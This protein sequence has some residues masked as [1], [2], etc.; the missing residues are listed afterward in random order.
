MYPISELFGIMN[1]MYQGLVE[2][3]GIIFLILLPF[4]IG[5][6]IHG[7]LCVIFRIHN[8]RAEPLAKPA[9][10][11]A[12]E[13]LYKNYISSRVR[14]QK[15]VL[16]DCYDSDENILWLSNGVYYS[17]APVAYAVALHEVGHALQHKE[18]YRLI[19]L[20]VSLGKFQNFFAFLGMIFAFIGIFFM[21]SW[22]YTAAVISLM[23][24]LILC[25]IT[26][27]TEVDASRRAREMLDT[28]NIPDEEIQHCKK[29]L[30]I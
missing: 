15:G 27:I 25:T 12:E 7:V 17:H 1:P 11:I 16:S 30:R 19:E 29:L 20:R 18:G 21:A 26:I 14:P 5:R 24:Y 28:L 6:I 13:F 2:A 8:L 10:D 4:I 22:G 3:L 9:K 23:I